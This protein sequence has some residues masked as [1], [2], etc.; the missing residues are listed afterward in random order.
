MKVSFF[1]KDLYA[2]RLFEVVFSNRN[3]NLNRNPGNAVPD[4]KSKITIMIKIMTNKN[5]YGLYQMGEDQARSW[6]VFFRSD[7]G[8]T[9]AR[10]ASQVDQRQVGFSSART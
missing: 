4:K 1:H 7:L 5:P 10:T 9:P 2:D 6:M 3:H 8:S